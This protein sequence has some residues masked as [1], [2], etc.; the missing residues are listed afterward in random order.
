MLGVADVPA[1]EVDDPEA[2]LLGE[3]DVRQVR[4]RRGGPGVETGVAL[5]PA[6]RVAHASGSSS[7]SRIGG[8]CT[9][10]VRTSSGW[11]VTRSIVTIAPELLPNTNTVPPWRVISAAAS[12]VS[13]A[14]RAASPGGASSGLPTNPRRT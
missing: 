4:E 9:T 14:R 3:T 7:S 1:G 2:Q 13:V 5:T 10:A 12:A 11:R 6:S 8:S